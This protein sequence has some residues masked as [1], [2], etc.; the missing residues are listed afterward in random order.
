[1][2]TLSDTG[3]DVW[4]VCAGGGAKAAARK[5]FPGVRHSPAQ[6]RG[7]HS[8]EIILFLPSDNSCAR[9]LHSRLLSAS[10]PIVAGCTTVFIFPAPL[11][12]KQGSHPPGS[13]EKPGGMG[14]RSCRDPPW[15]HPKLAVHEK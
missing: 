12:G 9:V 5:R 3:L 13:R 10:L 2:S 15:S 14:W 4:A 1:M 11:R 7:T 8:T 6:Q